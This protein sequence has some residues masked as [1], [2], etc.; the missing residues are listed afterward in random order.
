MRLLTL[1]TLLA[2]ASSA[3]DKENALLEAEQHVLEHQ[4][5][6][7]LKLLESVG[8]LPKKSPKRA[9]HQTLLG[10]SQAGLG[11]RREA[12]ASFR[13]AVKLRPKDPANKLRLGWH[14]LAELRGCPIGVPDGL[15]E[16]G[17]EVREMV[18]KVLR[19]KLQGE[20]LL[21]A[22]LLMARAMRADEDQA[23]AAEDL[24]QELMA[25]TAEA[26]PGDPF[27][28]RVLLES[29]HLYLQHKMF[30]N[31]VKM[32]QT[33]H[34]TAAP[35]S[36]TKQLDI[37][38]EALTTKQLAKQGG[39]MVMAKAGKCDRGAKGDDCGNALKIFREVPEP[40]M[41]ADSWWMVGMIHKNVYDDVD[42]AV[43]ALKK[44]VQ[45]VDDQA[46]WW[47]KLARWAQILHH[48]LPEGGFENRA[49]QLARDAMKA[50]HDLQPYSAPDWEEKVPGILEAGGAAAEGGGEAACKDPIVAAG[51]G[52][53]R[54]PR[55]LVTLLVFSLSQKP[56][57]QLFECH[58]NG[59][60][61]VEPEQS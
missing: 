1:T 5:A 31:S 48:R 29:G 58:D 56:A 38:H 23:K 32:Y 28:P 59:Q 51:A 21:D 2:A 61:V 12:A 17:E 44:A 3:T 15:A 35:A 4:W 18:G 34:D 27:R 30:P 52:E 42:P 6:K 41:T 50:N 60:W 25:A 26:A 14:L 24:L 46:G 10:Q 43:K 16:A 7:A 39:A 22:K 55:F 45:L 19:S 9:L 53:V 54:A 47:E 13:Q 49:I 20:V 57:F 8:R 11:L 37:L 36:P 33:A 40:E